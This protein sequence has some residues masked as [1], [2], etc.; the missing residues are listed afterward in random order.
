MKQTQALML[1]STNESLLFFS[2]KYYK[3]LKIFASK[4]NLDIFLVTTDSNNLKSLLENMKLFCDQNYDSNNISYQII[5]NMDIKSKK[6][7]LTA[8]IRTIIKTNFIKNKKLSLQDLKNMLGEYNITDTRLCQHFSH[9]REA[10][11]IQ[12]LEIKKLKNGLYEINP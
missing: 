4:F 11:S 8:D 6:T 2:K 12:G 3:K 9:V 10:L 7:T 5:K 1:K